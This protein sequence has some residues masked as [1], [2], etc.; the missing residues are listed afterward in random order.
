M[1][2]ASI[3]FGAT[4][5]GAPVLAAM[6]ALA[7]QL[8]LRRGHPRSGSSAAVASAAVISRRSGR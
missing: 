4:A 5:G 3:E 8:A 1:L 6:G 7:E 2:T